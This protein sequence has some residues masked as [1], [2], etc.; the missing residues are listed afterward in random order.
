MLYAG[1]LVFS[2][3]FASRSIYV[4]GVQWWSF[5]QGAD[6]RHPCG[7]G[8]QHPRTRDHPVVQVAFATPGLCSQ[9][10]GKDLPTEA[11][12]EFAARGGSTAPSLPGATSSRP[13]A[14]IWRTP[15]R[16]NFR[17]RT[18]A[19]TA[20][21]APRRSRRS[22]QRLRPA[23][24]DRQCLGMDDGLVFAEARGRCAEG[25]LHSPKSRVVP[26]ELRSL[27][28]AGA[29]PTS[30]SAQGDQGVGRTSARP[31]IAA[32]TVP[33]RA[34]PSRSTPRRAMSPTSSSSWVTTSASGTSAPTTAA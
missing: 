4:T 5:F 25:V 21:N 34:M 12:W 19:Q 17:D 28:D 15:G 1:S 23:R 20:S 3:A 26:K 13:A 27:L 18:S 16:V 10:A 14:S 33:P 7:P 9:Q 30:N 24:H 32:A 31:T 2:A 11:E 8:Q 6:W 22:R 29:N